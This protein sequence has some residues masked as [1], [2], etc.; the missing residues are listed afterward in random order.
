MHAMK[1]YLSITFCFLALATLFVA[2]KFAYAEDPPAP[3][4]SGAW[5]PV[6]GILPPKCY[7]NGNYSIWSFLDL[8]RAI[9]KLILGVSGAFALLMFIYGGF[10]WL[11]SGGEDKRVTLGRDTFI[12]AGTGLAIILGSWVF[13][14]FILITL[15]TPSAELTPEKFTKTAVLLG[16]NWNTYN[17]GASED[18]LELMA[19]SGGGSSKSKGAGSATKPPPPKKPAVPPPPKLPPKTPPKPPEPPPKEFPVVAPTEDLLPVPPKFLEP[20][21]GSCCVADR[22]QTYLLGPLGKTLEKNK[23]KDKGSQKLEEVACSNKKTSKRSERGIGIKH[24][25]IQST[26]VLWCKSGFSC[27]GFSENEGLGSCVGAYK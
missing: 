23:W 16:N 20:E 25:T 19:V 10:L 15:T 6:T 11:L 26:E 5:D 24:V 22:T 2:V 14:N 8:A 4:V 3:G 21:I 7:T 17:S 9:I 18:C 1:K 13:I 12:S 27:F